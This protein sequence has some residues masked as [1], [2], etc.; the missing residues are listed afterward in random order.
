MANPIYPSDVGAREDAARREAM[1]D[2]VRTPREPL[3]PYP[4]GPA[5][6][7]TESGDARFAT[8]QLIGFRHLQWSP[9]IAG[10]ICTAALS[11]VLLSFGAALGLGVVSPSTTWRD[12]SAILA[13]VSG[14]WLLLTSLA[15]FGLGGYLC[16]RLLAPWGATTSGEDLAA[17]EAVRE[18]AGG[19]AGL[20]DAIDF[21]DGVYGLLVWGVAILIGGFLAVGARPSNLSAPSL[22]NP[23]TS[24]AEPLLALEIDQLF[25]S[26]NKPTDPSDPEIRAQAARILTTGLGHSTMANDDRAYLVQLVQTRTGL[27]RPDAENRVAQ[28]LASSRDAVGRARHSAVILAFMIGAALMIGAAV[29]WLAAAAGG[30]HRDGIGSAP[31]FWRSWEVSHSFMLR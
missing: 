20:R 12:T 21:S 25:R 9:V 23:T 24:T 29:A 16:G 26:A 5:G 7:P 31:G 6:R 22:A 10:A 13:L 18:E 8:N 14:I 19:R 28:A 3:S 17:R 4:A 27:S 30:R 15:A 11:F 2:P 1:S